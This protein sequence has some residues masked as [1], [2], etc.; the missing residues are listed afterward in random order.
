MDI[1]TPAEAFQAV[2]TA[3][4]AHFAAQPTEFTGNHI[5]VANTASDPLKFTLCVWWEFAHPGARADAPPSVLPRACMQTYAGRR[6]HELRILSAIGSL[7]GRAGL[8]MQ[9]GEPVVICQSCGGWSVL[10]GCFLGHALVSTHGGG[11]AVLQA[12]SWAA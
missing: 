10:L 11:T 3:V 2:D 9:G 4:T 8:I 6:V 7:T 1:A 5:V 12:W